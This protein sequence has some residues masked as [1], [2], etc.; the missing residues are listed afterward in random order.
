MKMQEIKEKKQPRLNGTKTSLSLHTLK[1]R[2]TGI[3]SNL[4]SGKQ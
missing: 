2:S 4:A 1:I 3:A